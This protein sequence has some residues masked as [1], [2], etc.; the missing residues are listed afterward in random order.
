MPHAYHNVH[1]HLLDARPAGPVSLVKQA[2]E[3][4]GHNMTRLV[5]ARFHVQQRHMA[6][7]DQLR[8]AAGHQTAAF[9]DLA[10]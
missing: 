8:G 5:G 9:L 7:G 6:S 1:K 2:L 10:A 4:K 3:P